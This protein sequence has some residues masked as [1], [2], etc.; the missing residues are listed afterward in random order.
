MESRSSM[1]FHTAFPRSIGCAKV[2]GQNGLPAQDRQENRWMRP[3]LSFGICG[4][5]EVVTSS[6]LKPLRDLQVDESVEDVAGNMVWI[7]VIRKY[8][9]PEACVTPPGAIGAL[10]VVV[11]GGPLLFCK[12][13]VCKALFGSLSVLLHAETVTGACAQPA[14]GSALSLYDL[15][16][17]NLTALRV[18]GYEFFFSPTA[19][20]DRC[21]AEPG[22]ACGNEHEANRTPLLRTTEGSGSLAQPILNSEQARQ[23]CDTSVPFRGIAGRS[24]S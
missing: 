13:F 11:S 20:D 12:H 7:R 3:V 23:P 21:G 18:G 17:E 22:W 6:G 4:K 1:T 2:A 10:H 16:F 24:E 19:L 9:S 8:T 5:L 15:H 14:A